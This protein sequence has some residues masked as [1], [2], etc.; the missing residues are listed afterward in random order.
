MNVAINQFY[1]FKSK[2][3]VSSGLL[4]NLTVN[5]GLIIELCS[6]QRK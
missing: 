6:D 5:T 4:E 1:L 2:T 3:G